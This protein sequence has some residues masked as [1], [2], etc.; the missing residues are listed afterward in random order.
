MRSKS[1]GLILAIDKKEPNGRDDVRAKPDTGNLKFS[2]Q[3]DKKVAARAPHP[4]NLFDGAFNIIEI[5]PFASTQDIFQ[6]CVSRFPAS[7]A[8]SLNQ[9]IGVR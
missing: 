3:L 4:L 1:K 7:L 8:A 2:E 5:F 6:P 9:K